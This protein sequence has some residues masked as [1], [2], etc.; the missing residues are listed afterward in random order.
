MQRTTLGKSA[1]EG[2]PKLQDRT[3]REFSSS[4]LMKTM[5]MM[6]AIQYILAAAP[7]LGSQD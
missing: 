1:S 6:G 4:S 7:S 3:A 5:E 2:A